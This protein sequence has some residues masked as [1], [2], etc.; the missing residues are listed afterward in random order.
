MTD[1]R[2]ID[3]RVALARMKAFFRLYRQIPLCFLFSEAE[4]FQEDGYRWAPTSFTRRKDGEI[5]VTM[6]WD[7]EM[8]QFGGPPEYP[9]MGLYCSCPGFSITLPVMDPGEVV[10]SIFLC[11]C[12]PKNVW[13]LVTNEN[14][15]KRGRSINGVQTPTLIVA[16]PDLVQAALVD[17]ISEVDGR[18]L[19]RYITH[20]IFMRVDSDVVKQAAPIRREDGGFRSQLI[21]GNKHRILHGQWLGD[22]QQWCVY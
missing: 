12:Q 11:Y 1:E 6:P 2:L 15:S 20:V 21:N 18:K 13:Y 7:S 17:V 19:A 9:Q 5:I 4:R 10:S 3:E 14:D 8:A 16:K 22:N